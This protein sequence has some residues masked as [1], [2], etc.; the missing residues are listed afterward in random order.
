MIVNNPSTTIWWSPSP[1]MGSPTSLLVGV[2]SQGRLAL[3]EK[4]MHYE[5]II[6]RQQPHI[7]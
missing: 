1:I 4:E 7:L 6:F 5:G 3:E 2:N